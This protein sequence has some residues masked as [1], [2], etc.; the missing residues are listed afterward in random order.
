MNNVLN[1]VMEWNSETQEE[2]RMKCQECGTGHLYWKS[3]HVARCT[4]CGE[5]EML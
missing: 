1:F 2:R 5:E 4:Y 3:E